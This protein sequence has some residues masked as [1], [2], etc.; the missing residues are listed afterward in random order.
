MPESIADTNAVTEI[1]L[2]NKTDHTFK[3]VRI[4]VANASFFSLQKNDQ[5]AQRLTT[6]EE[7]PLEDLRPSDVLRVR[8][9]EG[10][11]TVT[12]TPV[13]VLTSDAE[14]QR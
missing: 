10:H 2:E 7:I 12:T 1:E 8:T 3:N 4:R 11:H 9:W 6:F 14:P 13:A 5:D